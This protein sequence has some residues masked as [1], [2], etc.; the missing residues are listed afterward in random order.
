MKSQIKSKDRVS[1]HGEVFTS[2]RE[3]NNMLDLVADESY[4]PE[5]TF[6]EPACGDG[7]FLIEIL[8]RKLSII[9]KYKRSQTE[10]EK[11]CFITVSSL[12]GVDILLD[13]VTE[14][15]N[16]L[17]DYVMEEYNKLFKNKCNPEFEKVVRYVF[18]KNILHG[19]ALTLLKSDGTPIRF[20]EWKMAMGNKVKRRDYYLSELLNPSIKEVND[21]NEIG[22]LTEPIEEYPAVNYMKVVDYV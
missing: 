6:L 10:Y 18:G 2:E 12:Y 1:N 13:N 15:Q 5:S 14:C 4:R 21:E 8:K 17:S 20:S 11:W 9:R 16:R 22:I 3:V 7:N 19:D